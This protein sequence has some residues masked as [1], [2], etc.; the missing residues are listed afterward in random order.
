MRSPASAQASVTLRGRYEGCRQS[1]TTPGSADP[2]SAAELGV[3]TS[4]VP[5]ETSGRSTVQAPPAGSIDATHTETVWSTACRRA[6][7]P[8][9]TRPHSQSCAGSTVPAGARWNVA[10]SPRSPRN[11]ARRSPS[12]VKEPATRFS[13][14]PRGGLWSPSGGSASHSTPSTTML[15]TPQCVL[16]STRSAGPSRAGLA[17]PDR[18]SRSGKLVGRG[19]LLGLSVTD[20]VPAAPGNESGSPPQPVSAISRATAAPPTRETPT[21]P[22]SRP[23]TRQATAGLPPRVGRSVQDRAAAMT[24]GATAHAHYRE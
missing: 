2:V 9:R 16:S 12:R 20:L 10:R 21:P 19:A 4:G 18:P 3:E 24:G 23:M 8:V 17:G 14:Q 22:S 7:T 15:R 1:P 6:G 11:S 13:S 5:T